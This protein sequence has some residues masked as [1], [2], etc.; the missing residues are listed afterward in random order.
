MALEWLINI[1]GW[2]GFLQGGDEFLNTFLGNVDV[3]FFASAQ[4]DFDFELVAS[5]QK[6]GGFLAADLLIMGAH[7]HGQAD[8]FDFDFACV[9]FFGAL[10]FFFFVFELSVVDESTYGRFGFW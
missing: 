6:L 7:L 10:L 8:T 4:M 3:G 9:R 1:K 2:M 5:L